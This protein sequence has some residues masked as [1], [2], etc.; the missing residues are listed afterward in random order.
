MPKGYELELM[1]HFQAQNYKVKAKGANNFAK[2]LAV[3][4]FF[5]NFAPKLLF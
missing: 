4:G 1:P 5:R 2:D 3:R